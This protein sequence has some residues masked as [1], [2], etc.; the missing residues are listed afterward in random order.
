MPRRSFKDLNFLGG[1]YLWGAFDQT[2]CLFT[3]SKYYWYSFFL[4]QDKQSKKL[5]NYIIISSFVSSSITFISSLASSSSEEEMNRFTASLSSTKID[6]WDFNFCLPASQGCTFFKQW[7]KSS[8][9]PSFAS[10]KPQHL[11]NFIMCSLDQAS[12]TH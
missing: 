4:T 7:I 1:V 10:F 11:N 2:G 3:N 12:S 6:S 5:E 8:S 9:V